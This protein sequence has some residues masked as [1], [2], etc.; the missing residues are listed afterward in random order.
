MSRMSWEFPK[1]RVQG[2]PSRGE[3]ICLEGE[4]TSTGGRSC[5]RG[6][7]SS[8]KLKEKNLLHRIDEKREDRINPSRFH[9]SGKKIFSGEED[10]CTSKGLSGEGK[11][12]TFHEEG[13][14]SHGKGSLEECGRGHVKSAGLEKKKGKNAAWGRLI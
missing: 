4:K 3:G 13:G 9:T 11:K 2:I 10:L 1:Q 5:P 7:R 6:R 12:A 8:G 14:L